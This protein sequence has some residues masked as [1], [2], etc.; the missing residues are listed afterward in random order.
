MNSL[1]II[2]SKEYLKSKSFWLSLF[3]AIIFLILLLLPSILFFHFNIFN[4]DELFNS[5]KAEK[6]SYP[7]LY[8]KVGELTPWVIV[9]LT[10]LIVITGNTTFYLFTFK[11]ELIEENYT[12]KRFWFNIITLL[13]F[14]WGTVSIIYIVKFT[15]R[16]TELAAILDLAKTKTLNDNE[17]VEKTSDLFTGF[18]NQVEH[19]TIMTIGIFILI[20]IFSRI[21]KNKQ[22][23]KIEESLKVTQANKTIEINFKKIVLQKEFV[24]NQLFLIDF[25]VLVGVILI[26]LFTSQISPTIGNN[27]DEKYV[28]IAGGIGMHIIMSQVIFLILNLRYKFK[29]YKIEFSKSN[30]HLTD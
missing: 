9:C 28:F 16:F 30:Q 1:D 2:F 11:D 13:F 27:F 10:A 26:S 22:L 23:E 25:P 21:V 19:Y 15:L 6:Y 20:D 24:A 5:F 12:T 18:I 4:L 7:R 8:H 3:F 14:V 17:L 29:E